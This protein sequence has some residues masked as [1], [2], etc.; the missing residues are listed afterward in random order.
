MGNGKIGVRLQEIHGPKLPGGEQNPDWH[1]LQSH[2]E[3][4]VNLE[5]PSPHLH[6]AR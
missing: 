2:G 1:L 3:L 4:G 5:Y 6:L